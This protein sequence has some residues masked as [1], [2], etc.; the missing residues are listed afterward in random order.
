MADNQERIG[1]GRDVRGTEFAVCKIAGLRLPRFESWSCHTPSDLR[2]RGFWRPSHAP[3]AGRISLRFSSARRGADADQYVARRRAEHAV[4][5]LGAILEGPALDGSPVRC[6]RCWTLRP[7]LRSRSPCRG[8]HRPGDHLADFGSPADPVVVWAI[9]SWL[10]RSLAWFLLVSTA[11]STD[12]S[13]LRLS[14]I[15][16][17]GRQQPIRGAQDP[18]PV[19]RRAPRAELGSGCAPASRRSRP[20]GSARQRR[21]CGSRGRLS[22]RRRCR[23]APGRN[24]SELV[25]GGT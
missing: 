13:M 24:A 14:P 7:K 2:K 1:V 23:P 20:G 3:R 17:A 22:D 18:L 10:S 12:L 16:L 5:G 6:R 8:C 15:G 4:E 11:A 9:W 25:E 21:R 19:T